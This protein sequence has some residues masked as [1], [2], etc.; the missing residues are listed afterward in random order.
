MLERGDAINQYQYLINDQSYDIVES[1]SGY[2]FR[3]IKN[4]RSFI[5]ANLKWQTV[6]FIL[7]YQTVNDNIIECQTYDHSAPCLFG[8]T[9]DFFADHI[10]PRFGTICSPPIL[11]DP[12]DIDSRFWATRFAVAEDWQYNVGIINTI[13]ELEWY[14]QTKSFD[15]WRQTYSVTPGFRYV[16]QQPETEIIRK[17]YLENLKDF[18]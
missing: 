15:D 13:G 16:I 17:R 3:H 10:I 11:L 5:L 2:E 18:A 8:F 7:V 4:P 12:N 6:D 1:G 14:D 9:S